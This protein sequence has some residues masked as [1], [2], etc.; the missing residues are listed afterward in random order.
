MTL[1]TRIRGLFNQDRS[2]K[3]NKAI[4]CA[5]GAHEK[6][7]DRTMG[8][9][10]DAYVHDW[11]EAKTRPAKLWVVVHVPE[12]APPPKRKSPPKKPKTSEAHLKAPAP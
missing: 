2:P 3:T 1:A 7:V 8:G 9:M 12:D 11:L 4:A 5:L 10:P 6:I